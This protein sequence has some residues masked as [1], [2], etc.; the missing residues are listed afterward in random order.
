VLIT[1]LGVAADTLQACTLGI[2]RVLLDKQS[3][4]GSISPE[5]VFR[6]IGLFAA[7]VSLVRF[8]EF[9]KKFYVLIIAMR[10]GPP[11]PPRKKKRKS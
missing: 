3:I 9:Y 4:R 6:A 5:Q 7:W 11:F 8:L 1:V 2:L 10:V